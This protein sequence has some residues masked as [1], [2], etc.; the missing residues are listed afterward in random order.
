MWSVGGAVRGL[1]VLLPNLAGVLVDVV[2]QTINRLR[3]MV[4]PKAVEAYCSS[5][6]LPS[7]RVY[8]RYVR[9]LVDSAIGSREVEIRVQARRWFCDNEQ[10]PKRTFAEQVDG[11]TTRYARRTGPLRETLETIGLALAGRAGARLAQ[12][13]GLPTSRSSLLRLIRALPDPPPTPVAVVGWTISPP[14]GGIVTA[15]F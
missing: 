12:R 11:L 2:E 14:V 13:L 8:S 10:C 15:L 4:R 5:C 7:R 1:E 3:I 6:S 9:C